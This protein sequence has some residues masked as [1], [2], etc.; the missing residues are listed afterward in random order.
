MQLGCTHLL[1]GERQLRHIYPGEEVPVLRGSPCR[2]LIDSGADTNL[3]DMPLA[4]QLGVARETLS[5]PIHATALDGRLIC[6]VTHR[7]FMGMSAKGCPSISVLLSAARLGPYTAT[8]LG[9]YTTTRPIGGLG[10]VSPVS[11]E[12]GPSQ[13]APD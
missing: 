1:A 7:T 11:T 12:T 5:Q 8:S 6:Q 3:M 4:S 2:V 13:R 10:Y 9:D